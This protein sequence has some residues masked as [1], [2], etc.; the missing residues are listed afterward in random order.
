M[1]IRD[2]LYPTPNA[3]AKALM[4]DSYKNNPIIFPPKEALAK[5]EY[6]KFLGAKVSQEIEGA[7]THIRAE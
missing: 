4:D 3:A 2:S 5:C 1:C 6:G 7:M